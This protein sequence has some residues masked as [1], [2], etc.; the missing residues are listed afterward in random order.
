MKRNKRMYGNSKGSTQVSE[1]ELNVWLANEMA[2]PAK[3]KAALRKKNDFYMR[4]CNLS[5]TILKWL[6]APQD[7][8]NG[9]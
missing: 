3:V 2:R 8:K 1:D 6:R 4:V 7:I 5:D 9:I